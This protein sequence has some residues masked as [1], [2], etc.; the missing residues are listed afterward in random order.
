[1]GANERKLDKN[2]RSLRNEYFVFIM[3]SPF[4]GCKLIVQFF[5]D[6][7]NRDLNKFAKIFSTCTQQMYLMNGKLSAENYN[8]IHNQFVDQV[9][10]NHLL[11]PN[12]K[13]LDETTI[14][15]VPNE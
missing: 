3:I 11:I 9:Y 6:G 7:N 8:G 5:H 4:K 15:L 12:Y 14:E 2:M 10:T 1:M 13:F